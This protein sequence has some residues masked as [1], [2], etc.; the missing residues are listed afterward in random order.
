VVAWEEPFG[1]FPPPEVRPT[2]WY[3]SPG[4]EL[5]QDAPE[6]ADDAADTIDEYRS[7]PSARPEGSIGPDSSVSVRRPA[8]EW[9]PTDDET[10]VSYE[11]PLLLVPTV[12]VGSASADLWLRSSATD[13]D[14]QV[15]L[16]EVRPDGQETFVQSGWLRASQRKVDQRRSTDLQPLP[17]QLEED[18]APL[19]PDEFALVRVEVAPFAHAFRLGSRI[20]MTISAPGGDAPAWRFATLPGVQDNA[21]ARSAGRPSALVLPVVPGADVPTPLP[22]C[23]SLR[24]QPCRAY[25]GPGS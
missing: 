4:G 6:A 17:T 9:A 18:A 23:P 24:G 16:S 5:R 12:L 8:Y 2:S 19:D 11:S 22:A 15:T 25:G 20:R 14:V 1:S 10:S 3:L 13:T 7:D 21:V